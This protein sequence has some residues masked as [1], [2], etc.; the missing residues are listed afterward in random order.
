MSTYRMDYSAIL[1]SFFSEYVRY[2][3]V[4]SKVNAHCSFSDMRPDYF[5]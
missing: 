5:L 2:K 3:T 1:F 4:N